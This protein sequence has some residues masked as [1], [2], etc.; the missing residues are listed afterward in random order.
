MAFFSFGTRVLRVFGRITRNESV[1]Y[2]NNCRVTIYSRLSL[3]P[4]DRKR[5]P[6]VSA[7]PVLTL[8]KYASTT[9]YSKLYIQFT[10]KKC[11]TRNAKYISKVAYTKGVVI[12]KC[13]GCNNNH[14]IADNLNWFSDLNGKKNIEEILAEKGETVR[15]FTSDNLCEVVNCENI[16]FIGEK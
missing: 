1:I 6:V 16:S 11:D 3:I 2:R 14:L 7:Q 5:I 10:C 12:I 13:D 9:E 8:K 4:I 15:K